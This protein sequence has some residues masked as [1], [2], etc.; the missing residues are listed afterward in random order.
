MYNNN[1]DVNDLAVNALN[2]LKES[3]HYLAYQHLFPTRPIQEQPS[4]LNSSLTSDYVTMLTRLVEISNY[5]NAFMGGAWTTRG[6]H[7]EISN[8]LTELDIIV[9]N[10]HSRIVS[11]SSV[12]KKT[13][14]MYELSVMTKIYLDMALKTLDKF[15]NLTGNFTPSDKTFYASTKGANTDFYG[16]YVGE[17]DDLLN[18]YNHLVSLFNDINK[19]IPTLEPAYKFPVLDLIEVATELVLSHDILTHKEGLRSAL[20]ADILVSSEK[21]VTHEDEKAY[22]EKLIGRFA[23]KL[24]KYKPNHFETKELPLL[25]YALVDFAL[26]DNSPYDLSEEDESWLKEF[27]LTTNDND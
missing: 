11:A 26:E 24:E 3:R 12:A 23:S 18:L 17:Y 1:I 9:C 8:M 7:F 2:E 22:R 16:E 27:T 19:I 6:V 15:Y 20:N 5:L 14:F 13:V 25:S 21:I 10:L 4:V